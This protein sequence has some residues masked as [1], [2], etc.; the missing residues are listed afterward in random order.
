V[1]E[2]LGFERASV[3]GWSLGG[4]IA[5]T[6]ALQHPA[7]TD[8]LILLF[9]DPRRSSCGTRIPSCPIATDRHIWHTARASSTTPLRIVSRCSRRPYLRPVRRHCGGRTGTAFL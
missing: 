5:Q 7:R 8:K 1:I 4:F 3:M 2:A 6:V 9:T